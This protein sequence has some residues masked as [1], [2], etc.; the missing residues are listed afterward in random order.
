MALIEYLKTLWR[1][2]YHALPGRAQLFGQPSNKRRQLRNVSR[3]GKNSCKYHI[4]FRRRFALG[5]VSM[6]G[7][8]AT[9]E[10]RPFLPLAKLKHSTQS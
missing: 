10:K 1:C 2:N 9:T 8:V 5:A 4:S 6:V 7:A 3:I